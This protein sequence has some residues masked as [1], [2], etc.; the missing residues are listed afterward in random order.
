MR[1]RFRYMSRDN[2]AIPY[3]QIISLSPSMASRVRTHPDYTTRWKEILPM[4][5]GLKNK[6]TKYLGVHE[7]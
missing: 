1:C 7:R 5:R 3:G 4:Q 6:A 2:V